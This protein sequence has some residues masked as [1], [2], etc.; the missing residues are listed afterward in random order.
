MLVE[1]ENVE[2]KIGPAGDVRL[3]EMINGEIEERNKKIEVGKGLSNKQWRV[4]EKVEE[5]KQKESKKKESEIGVKQK[6]ENNDKDCLGKTPMGTEDYETVKEKESEIDVNP[7]VA[8]YKSLSHCTSMGHIDPTYSKL[9][10]Y[11]N[12]GP[13]LTFKVS[14]RPYWSLLHDRIMWKWCQCLLG[15]QNW[16]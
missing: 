8:H 11:W 9:I 7:I 4:I 5:L 14:K 1:N 13:I 3:E 2:N 16:N 12:H 10:N 6:E 15:G